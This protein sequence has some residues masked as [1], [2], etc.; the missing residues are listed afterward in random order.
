MRAI[1]YLS[2]AVLALL[3]QVAIAASSPLEMLQ[4]TSDQM[5]SA[6]K[7]NKATLKSNPETVYRIVNQILVPHVDLDMMS[8]L[9]LGR[10]VW[11]Q[12]TPEQRQRFKKEFTRLVINT[13]SA[14]LASYTNE[15]V[16]FMPIR[17]GYEGRSRVQV[18]SQ[19]IRQDGP[20]VGVNYRVQNMG[21]EW[22]VYD[23]TVEGVSMIESFRSQFAED[24]SSGS[25]DSLLDKMARH[26][27]GRD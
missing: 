15:T 17:G 13:Y 22:L 10:N 16:K 9:V 24:L 23:F 21:G 1:R 27:S 20:P 8:R 7:A 12:A 18:Q 19:I 11:M 4:P 25:M 3:C 5:L 26:N 6:L 2:L 14:A